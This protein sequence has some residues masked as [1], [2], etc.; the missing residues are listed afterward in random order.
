MCHLVN[1]QFTSCLWKVCLFCS[2]E[3]ISY[4]GLYNTT[5]IWDNVKN[6]EPPL[7]IYLQQK[8]TGCCILLPSHK[9][10]HWNGA[11]IFN[12]YWKHVWNKLKYWNH[13]LARGKPIL[14]ILKVLDKESV[15]LKVLV[16]VNKFWVTSLCCSKKR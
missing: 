1:S 7:K 2:V 3:N 10:R 14:Q 16:W 4:T 5:I 13:S 8:T 6:G 9:E 15:D 12:I 11:N